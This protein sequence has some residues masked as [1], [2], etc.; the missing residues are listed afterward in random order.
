MDTANKALTGTTTGKTSY[1]DLA[2]AFA[3]LKRASNIKVYCNYATLYGQLVAMTDSTGRPIFQ[4]NAQNGAE[5]VLIGGQVKLEDSLTDGQILIGDPTK[6]VYNM[7]QDVMIESD[8]DIKTHNVIYSGYAR[9]E[10]ALID[11]KAFALYTV[12]AA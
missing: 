5:G 4:P 7:V 9:G 1:I 3:T 2:G 8:K 6:V 12:K 11:P 10:G